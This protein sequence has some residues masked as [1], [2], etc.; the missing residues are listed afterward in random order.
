M[1]Q[2]TSRKSQIFS[3]EAILSVLIFTMAFLF[4][5][6]VVFSK[7][8]EMNE[9]S[10]SRFLTNIALDSS[11]T[12]FNTKGVPYDWNTT[13]YEKIGLEEEDFL[14]SMEKMQMFLSMSE[15]EVLGNLGI[16]GYHIFINFTNIYPY[17]EN[18]TYVFGTAPNNPYILARV[19]RF[20]LLRNETSRI[21]M[22]ME[23][24]VW[25]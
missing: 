14:V 19:Y 8:T 24:E 5:G 22:K 16:E 12:L 20:F 2:Y 23:M 3:F 25:R 7:I 17:T 18:I 4:L 11:D 10:E 21:P 1:A 6:N 15:E 13:N 9:V